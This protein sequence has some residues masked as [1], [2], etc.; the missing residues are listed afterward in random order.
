M[1]SRTGRVGAVGQTTLVLDKPARNPV[2]LS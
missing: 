2:I 1:F